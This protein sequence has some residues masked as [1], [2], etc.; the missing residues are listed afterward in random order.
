[1]SLTGFSLTQKAMDLPSQ[2]QILIPTSTILF[3][4]G[5]VGR[6]HSIAHAKLDVEFPRKREFALRSSAKLDV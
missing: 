6:S 2:R 1:M 3:F 4:L 5:H